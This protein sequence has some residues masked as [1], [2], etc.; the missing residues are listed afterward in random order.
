MEKAQRN[1]AGKT[2]VGSLSG[3]LWEAANILRGPVDAA[4]FKTYIFPLLFF[5]RVSDVYDEEVAEALSESEGD[6]E[7][8]LFP[9]NH[10]FQIPE[11]CHWQDIRAKSANI[12]HALQKAMRGIEQA[13][14]IPCTRSSV[15]RNG[16]TRSVFQ[17]L[18]SRT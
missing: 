3:H 2:K 12:G 15:T 13:N 17:M 16:R 9:E 7:Y 4:D 8:A 11:R 18:C 6:Q 14:P 5:K 10:R 1:D